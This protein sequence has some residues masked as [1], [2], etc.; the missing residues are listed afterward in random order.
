MS[1]KTAQTNPLKKL[2]QYR[3][4]YEEIGLES[5]AVKPKA[6]NTQRTKRA[7]RV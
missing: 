7:A 1:N 4:F 5:Q 6:Q 3:L 2:G